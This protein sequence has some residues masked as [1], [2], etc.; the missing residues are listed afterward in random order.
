MRSRVRW[1]L[2]EIVRA[3][4][5]AQFSKYW[6]FPFSSPP[7]GQQPKTIKNHYS[8][9]RGTMVFGGKTK[10]PAATWAPGTVS[11][12]IQ[13]EAWSDVSGVNKFKFTSSVLENA[14]LEPENKYR[15]DCKHGPHLS[16][17]APPG[18]TRAYT[19]THTHTPHSLAS[20]AQPGLCLTAPGSLLCSP[21]T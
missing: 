17:P 11:F 5:L 6:H 14:A 10:G 12:L 7:R 15:Q 18:C 21:S 9:E 8:A 3:L 2:N 13:A 19:H 16:K 20:S 1:G 4:H